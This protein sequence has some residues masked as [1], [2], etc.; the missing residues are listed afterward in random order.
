[1]YKITRRFNEI[2]VPHHYVCMLLGD[3]LS[4]RTWAV[5]TRS[6]AEKDEPSLEGAEA[7]LA[8]IFTWSNGYSCIV[9]EFVAFICVCTY[10]HGL[11]W[12]L[13]LGGHKIIGFPINV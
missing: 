2:C 1:M 12:G 8:E 13:E 4:S 5:S 7:S 6:K 10:V 11:I 3:L 9:W